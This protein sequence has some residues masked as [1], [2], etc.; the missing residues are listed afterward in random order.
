MAFLLAFVSCNGKK[1]EVI[2]FDNS[3][4]LALAPN[5]YWALVPDPYAAF[6]KDVGWNSETI[7]HCRSGEILQVIGQ[8]SD[9][10]RV[11]WYHFN[12]GWLPETCLS[13]YSNRFKAETAASQ[14]QK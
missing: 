2:E 14:I 10:E 4:P 8:A 7:S 13:I 12:E 1:E 5:V 11:K 6:T 9:S 3:H